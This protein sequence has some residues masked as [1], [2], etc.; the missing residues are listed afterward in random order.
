MES[1]ALGLFVLTLLIPL[2]EVILSIMK[3][4]PKYGLAIPSLSMLSN[5]TVVC[6][7]GVLLRDYAED[8][9]LFI[10]GVLLAIFISMLVKLNKAL[11]S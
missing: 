7:Y 2:N 3:Y 8:R 5:L 6:T 10:A 1:V 11:K 4:K 9:K